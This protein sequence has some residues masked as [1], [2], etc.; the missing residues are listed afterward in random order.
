[1]AKFIPIAG[2]LLGSIGG[3]TYSRNRFG[4]YAKLKP[5]PKQPGSTA[6]MFVRSNFNR[7]ATAW[8]LLTP[9]LRDAWNAYAAATPTQLP[10]G[11][12][13]LLSGA[14]WFL[15]AHASLRYCG[16]IPGNVAPRPGSG[17]LPTPDP[18]GIEVASGK[19]NIEQMPAAATHIAVWYQI[20]SAGQSQAGNRWV[21]YYAGTVA[22]YNGGP[23]GL[24]ETDAILF[25]KARIISQTDLRI[26]PV[27][28]G[29]PYAAQ[30]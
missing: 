8:R 15:A 30:P 23:G 5:T 20:A 1:M 11:R 16:G 19:I 7:G 22:G 28:V 29:G 14:Q 3:V 26:S 18:T 10:G 17:V 6:Q 13:D 9:A 2:Q 25:V 21:S 27:M 12:T 4:P 24:P